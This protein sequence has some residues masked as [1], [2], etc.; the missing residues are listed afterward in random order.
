MEG[1][2]LVP[3]MHRMPKSSRAHGACSLELPQPKLGPV[4]TRILL[5]RHGS[6]FRTKPGTSSPVFA[7]Y[8]I[9]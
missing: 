7:S 3:M 2:H 6:W 5:C 4:T 1:A 9:G 8:R